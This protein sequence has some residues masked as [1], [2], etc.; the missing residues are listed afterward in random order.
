ML[1]FVFLRRAT[2]ARWASAFVAF[3]F[4]LHPLHVG[5]VAWIAERKDV[6][7]AFFWFLALYCYVR[8]TER[9]SP[10]RYLLVVLPFCLG[11]MSKPMLVTFPFT[12]LLLDYL[13]SASGGSGRRSFGR[14]FRYSR[15]PPPP[16][17]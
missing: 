17:W 2:R 1:L 12:L 4:A 14:S 11:L 9:P 3:M 8:Y 10:G 6:L 7:S 15:F 16:A 13:A 5:S